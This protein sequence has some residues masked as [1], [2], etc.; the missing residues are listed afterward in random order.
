MP[1]MSE[2]TCTYC[3]APMRPVRVRALIPGRPD[4]TELRCTQPER[5]AQV[6]TRRDDQGILRVASC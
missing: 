3:N 5:H 6:G 1:A 2:P 4:R